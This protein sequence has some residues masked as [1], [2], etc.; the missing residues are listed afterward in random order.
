MKLRFIVSKTA[1]FFFFID[2]LSEW[3]IYYRKKYNEEWIRQLGELTR[4][5]KI[6]LKNFRLI[7]QKYEK[8]GIPKKIRR[9]FYQK[10]DDMKASFRKIAKLLSKKEVNILKNSFNIFQP[11][12]ERM[13][14][15]YLIVLNQN[16][17]LMSFTY[18]KLNKKINLAYSKLENFYGDKS[19]QHYLCR[20]FLIIS[21]NH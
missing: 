18:R 21:P 2:N 17:E 7:M 5:E 14:N 15:E 10:S 6:A 11:R 9:C 4:Q 3:N 16:Q 19:T 12:F 13:W 20:V 8:I 1:N